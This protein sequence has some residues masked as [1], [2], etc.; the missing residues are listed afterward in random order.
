M[1]LSPV[2]IWNSFST[3][4]N[5]KYAIPRRLSVATDVPN[6]NVRNSKP[7]CELGAYVLI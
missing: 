1:F 6:I 4:L 5:G 7:A 3:E 2:I